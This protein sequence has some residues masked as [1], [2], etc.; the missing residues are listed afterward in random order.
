MP[1]QVRLGLDASKEAQPWTCSLGVGERYDALPDLQGWH[2]MIYVLSGALTSHIA[3][4]TMV[5]QQ[6]GFYVFDSAQQHAYENNTAELV[7]FLKN[8]MS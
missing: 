6:R 4:E 3:A 2:E 1:S 8:V 5:L 7:R